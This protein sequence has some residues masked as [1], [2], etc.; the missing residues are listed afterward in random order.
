MEPKT[1]QKGPKVGSEYWPTF[2]TSHCVR[3]V[4]ALRAWQSPNKP[5]NKGWLLNKPVLE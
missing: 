1:Y 3:T 5:S 4:C 2:K